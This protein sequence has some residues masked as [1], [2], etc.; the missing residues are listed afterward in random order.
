[1]KIIVY[2]PLYSSIGHYY[3]Y[4]KFI[5][6]MLSDIGFIK[7]IIYIESETEGKEYTSISSKIKI[8]SPSLK[9]PSFQ[10]R[11][12][13]AKGILNKLSLHYDALNSYRTIVDYINKSD[14]DYVFFTS[15][16]QISFWYS[17]LKLKF[18]YI[19]SAISIKWIYDKFTIKHLIYYIYNKYLTNSSLLLVTEKYYQNILKQRNFK[20]V[21]VL[22]DR[23]LRHKIKIVNNSQPQ[24]ISKNRLLLTTLGTIS[25]N[26]NPIDFIKELIAIGFQNKD[27]I[28]KICGKSIDATK[29]MVYKLI[30]NWPNIYFNDD[31]ISND[32][33]ET[34]VEEAD[35][36]VIPYNYSYTK[37]ATS[38]IMWDCLE[39]QKPFICPNVAPLSDYITNYKIGYLYNSSNLDSLLDFL[40]TNRKNIKEK[41]HRN[42]ISLIENKNYKNTLNDFEKAI[43]TLTV[44]TNKL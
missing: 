23:Y 39:R 33:F 19:V 24:Y 26:K 38:G 40:I 41:M 8:H 35:F 36:I 27:A 5:L 18:P 31:Y 7:E 20:R 15:N 10:I 4:N 1:M 9:N 14:C 32:E 37:F 21:E 17:V 12:M 13:Q 30:K 11:T 16:G 42:Y 2:D 43:T 29:Y 28:Y 44:K 22:N 3:R 34:L 25:K 6:E